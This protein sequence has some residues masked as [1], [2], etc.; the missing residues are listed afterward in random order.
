MIKA[1]L[2]IYSIF[3]ASFVY[4]EEETSCEKKWNDYYDNKPESEQT[5]NDSLVTDSLVKFMLIEDCHNNYESMVERTKE[6]RDW[7]IDAYA[8]G[9]YET[10]AENFSILADIMDD[11][12]HTFLAMM[13]ENGEYF[14]QDFA[15]AEEHYRTASDLGNSVAQFNLGHMYHRGENAKMIRDDKEALKFWE[16][17]AKQGDVKAMRNIF[18]I[19]Y[20]DELSPLYDKEEAVKWVRLAAENDDPYAQFFLAYHYH[21][22]QNGFT[23][24][25]QKSMKWYLLSAAQGYTIAQHNLG[26]MYGNGE[27][28]DADIV[29]AYMWF[30]IAVMNGHQDSEKARNSAKNDLTDEQL[31]RAEELSRICVK[32]NYKNCGRFTT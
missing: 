13:H 24:D 17:A 16:L 21:Y 30:N 28:V 29:V 11:T 14:K 5:P 18:L 3:T 27:G 20:E 32:N 19:F 6:M 31:K 10:A 23:Q 12:A 22:G 4:A 8:T 26:V 2:L 1:I 25:Y 9:D 15:L 7:A